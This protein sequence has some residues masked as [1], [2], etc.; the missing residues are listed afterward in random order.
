MDKLCFIIHGIGEQDPKYAYNIIKKL[1]KQFDRVSFIPICW[2]KIFDTYEMDLLKKLEK[3]N[4]G[5]IHNFVIMHCADVIMYEKLK[6][7]LYSY[8]DYIL[9]PYKETDISFIAHSLGSIIVSNYIWDRKIN[10]KNFFTVGSPLALYS[11]GNEDFIK[12][13]KV[14]NWINIWSKYDCISYPLKVLNTQYDIAVKKDIEVNSWN[15]FHRIFRL[16]HMDYFDKKEF[17]SVIYNEWKQ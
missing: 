17:Y 13:T 7:K 14:E 11:L 6:V 1:E 9:E 15:I 8:L 3:Y 2:S 12:P 4:L 16:A 10:V 5:Y